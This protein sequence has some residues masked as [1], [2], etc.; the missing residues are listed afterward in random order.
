MRFSPTIRKP[1]S[2]EDDVWIGTHAIVLPGITIGKGAVVGRAISFS[3]E[4]KD[5]RVSG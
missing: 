4:A 5:A 2:I 1:V 3:K